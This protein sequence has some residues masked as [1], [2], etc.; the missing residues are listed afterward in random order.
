MTLN[1]PQ[2]GITPVEP[3]AP[4]R[5][6]LPGVELRYNAPSYNKDYTI[7]VLDVLDRPTFINPWSLPPMTI[8][9]P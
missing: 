3:K 1:T 7:Q 6:M 5:S 4:L 9:P 2:T 8:Q